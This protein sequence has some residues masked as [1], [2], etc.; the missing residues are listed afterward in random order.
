VDRQQLE[1]FTAGDRSAVRQMYAE[2]G[3]AVYALAYRVLRDH[4]L[5]EEAVQ[6][7]MLNAWRNAARF[8]PE[9]DIGPWLYTIARRAAIDV[10]RREQR[11][12]SAELVD[13]DIAVLPN[14]LDEVWQAWQIHQALAQIPE[15]EREIVR[16]T[17]Y[18]G[19]TQEQT[20]DRLGIPVGTVKSRS[21]RAYRRLADLLGH[22]REATA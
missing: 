2:Y 7:T 12:Q 6:T 19:L 1:R 9:R 4:G 17:H 22:L 18:L 8:D 11:H 5:A 15:A 3:R 13:T 21:H 20:A 14:S 16:C 10:Y